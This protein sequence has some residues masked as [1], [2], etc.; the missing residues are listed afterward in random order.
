MVRGKKRKSG[1]HDEPVCSWF[2]LNI[3]KKGVKVFTCRP[4]VFSWYHE[5]HPAVWQLDGQAFG[6]P[7][8]RARR[9][10]REQGLAW[11]C[12]QHRVVRARPR[13][14]IVAAVDEHG[15]GAGEPALTPFTVVVE[16]YVK[17]LGGRIDERCC[18]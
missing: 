4:C 7:Y 3:K 8:C 18:L 5:S 17:R 1:I 9:W 2:G 11:T 14:T 6:W 12:N 15:H 13:Q 10:Y 16:R